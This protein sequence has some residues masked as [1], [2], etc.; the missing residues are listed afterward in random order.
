MELQFEWDDRKAAENE[1]NHGIRFREATDVFFDPR[2][3]TIFDEEHSGHE[4]R[5][6][7]IGI[8]QAL[9]ILSVIHSDRGNVIRIISARRA[10]REER[11]TYEADNPT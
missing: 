10:T 6:K 1:R 3:V 4:D 11:L 2:V 5:F 9:R 8:S 7:A